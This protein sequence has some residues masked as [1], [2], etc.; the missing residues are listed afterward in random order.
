[1]FTVFDFFELFGPLVGAFIGATRG[2]HYFGLAGG[3]GG[4]I[5]GLVIGFIAGKLPFLLAWAILNIKG[6]S[7]AKLRRVFQDDQYYIYHLALASLMARGEDISAEK[8]II[9]AL[10][11]SDEA[12]RRRF[13]WG[14]LQLGYP[15]LA[16]QLEGFDA[17]KPSAEHIERVK[18][19]LSEPPTLTS[20]T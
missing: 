10:L 13:G 7:T 16:A 17:E 11:A 5:L 20:T 12:D 9:V 14:S 4:A 18:L 1:M 2:F 15:D 8:N 3:I 6:K 19:L